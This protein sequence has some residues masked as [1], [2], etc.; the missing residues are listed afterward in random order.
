M[1]GDLRERM[2]PRPRHSRGVEAGPIT[3]DAGDAKPKRD[4]RLPALSL[5]E[6]TAPAP[7]PGGAHPRRSGR[8][9]GSGTAREDARKPARSAAGL[10][11]AVSPR[12]HQ[13]DLLGAQTN[14]AAP[15]AAR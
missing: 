1:R 6:R 15:G 13:A 7:F 5:S 2:A 11:A 10:T 8:A 4:A 9:R 14:S 12:R 3:G